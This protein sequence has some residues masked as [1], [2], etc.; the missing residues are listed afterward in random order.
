MNKTDIPEYEFEGGDAPEDSGATKVQSKEDRWKDRAYAFSVEAS[1][2]NNETGMAMERGCTDKICVI[3]FF[4]FL[5][6]M[7]G[8]SI[9]CVSR[10]NPSMMINPYD[11]EGNI[12]GLAGKNPLN[13]KDYDF[14]E[15]P[16]LYF[17][18]TNVN[19]YSGSAMG[20]IQTPF[21]NAVCVKA[22]PK[23]VTKDSTI[24][25]SPAMIAA[26]PGY[27]TRCAKKGS[28]LRASASWMNICKPIASQLPESEKKNW[29]YIF[30]YV[31]E[32]APGGQGMKDMYNSS[33]A[34]FLSMFLAF[35]WAI[36]YIYLMSAFAE[37]IAWG[38][39]GL[40]MLGLIGITIA[41]FGYYATTK[42]EAKNIALAVGLCGALASIVF[43]ICLK[44]GWSSLHNAIDVI[45]A[46]AD[47]LAKTKR[48]IGVPFIYFLVLVFF[49][50]FW[51]GCII[52]VYSMGTI[53][54]NLDY[55][56]NG[57]YIP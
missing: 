25:C 12:C 18:Y 11:Y 48:I 4:S 46:S 14:R 37:Y 35:V 49:F 6:T 20:I 39:I 32:K 19:F 31:M 17:S 5:A 38:I 47:F 28:E 3:I 16:K 43:C 24:Q 23:T 54:P 26:N 1:G 15:Y 33:T 55:K 9:Y 8:V 36:L 40:T 21:Q 53:K 52:C 27:K 51:I 10:G 57:V 56:L 41:S 29:K 34:I 2:L 7:F 45:D 22:C 44:C 30:D 13:Q 42:T 50:F